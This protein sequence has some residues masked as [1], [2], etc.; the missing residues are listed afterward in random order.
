MLLPRW[1]IGFEVDKVL[2]DT[3]DDEIHE[4]D[5]YHQGVIH[6]PRGQN[7]GFTPFLLR[8]YFLIQNKAYVI[9]W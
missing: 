4:T 1:G 7:F 2:E 5:N 9:K 3:L 6:K 8:G